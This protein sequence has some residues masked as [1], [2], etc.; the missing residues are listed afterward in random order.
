[1]PAGTV[2]AIV[3]GLSLVL[4]QLEDRLADANSAADQLAALGI[5]FP[6][7]ALALLTSDISQIHGA[8]APLKQARQD[9][10]T[11]IS[12]NVDAIQIVA[13]GATVVTAVG[14]LIGKIE[15]LENT[16]KN[17]S[18][19]GAGVSAT[20]LTAY[21]ESFGRRLV[22]D[23]LISYLSER[24]PTFTGVLSLLGVVDN[25]PAPGDP[26]NPA[27]PAYMVRDLHLDRL[28]QAVQSPKDLLQ[29]LYGWGNPN[30]D[31]QNL[32]T[33]IAAFL[34]NLGMVARVESPSPGTI[35]LK[36]LFLD[37]K[38]DPSVSPEG[39]SG[40]FHS[41][42][43]D[44]AT[45][46]F[47]LAPNWN[48]QIAVHGKFDAE[49]GFKIA[50]PLAINLQPAANF[51]GSITAD[52]TRSGPPLIILGEADGSRLEAASVSAGAKADILVDA[53][54]GTHVV[55]G[56]S[57]G[58]SGGK[59]VIDGSKGDGFL[60][61][62][63]SGVHI[64]SDF[65]VQGTWDSVRGVQISGGGGLD[66]ALPVHADLGPIS[67]PTLHL[68]TTLGNGGITI[69]ISADLNAK[70]GP[71]AASVER[72][73][74]NANVTFPKPHGN[75][76]PLNIEFSFH[77]PTGVGASIDAGIVSGGGFLGFDPQRK[78]YSG[79]L[80]L[81]LADIVSVK[82]IGIIDTELPDGTPGYSFIIVITTDF[83]PI[84]LS[85]GFTL[86][87]VGGV[88]GI[89]RTMS[90]DAL[91]DGL[92][93]HHLDSVLFPPDPVANAP[94]I[95]S[96]LRTFFP[97]AAD[98]Y[99]FGPMFSLGW[100][101]PT[102]VKL[103]VGVV[104]EVPDPVRLAILGQ[105]K[106]AL[107]TEDV[108]LIDI[109]IDV[110]GDVDFGAELLSIDGSMYDSHVLIYSTEGDM[111]FRLGWGDNPNF[112]LSVGGLNPRFQ[113]PPG[114]PQMHRARVSIGDGDNPRLACDSYYAVTSNSVQFGASVDLYAEEAGFSIHGYI[115]FDAL[116]I[117]S[118]FSFIIEFHA[119]FDVEFEGASLMSI[120]V[121][122]V[123]S[124]PHPWHVHGDAHFHILF[125]SVSPS[126]DISWGDPTPVLLPP[127]EVWPVL[128]NAL[129]D[130][131]AWTTQFPADATPSVSLAPRPP[132]DTT[133]IVHPLGTLQV[134]E[135]VVP[136]DLTISKF[137]SG[138]P[139]DGTYFTI[140]GVTI[141][142]QS[143]MKQS[144]TDNFA[145]GQFADLSDDDKLGKPSYQPFDNG[146]AIGSHDVVF[147]R[148]VPRTV[149]YEDGYI[150]EDNQVMRFGR[151]FAL[152]LDLHL[153]YSRLGAS[154]TAGM[155]TSGL[156]KYTKAGTVGAVKSA[157]ISY[158]IAGTDDLVIRNDLSAATSHAAASAA[159]QSYLQANP[160]T[161]G[162]LQVVA[163][164]EAMAA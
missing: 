136:L 63:L 73:G 31:A 113:P 96:D 139:S 86:N 70:L 57:V 14:V 140:A 91:R 132:S 129:E 35:V 16:V 11:L 158:V 50:P 141:D 164:H 68:V 150:D 115:G 106:I 92:R 89:N 23:L 109:N 8:V 46:S 75:L 12:G 119:G 120:G 13:A 111:A 97:P 102:L 21:A 15:Q 124:G 161:A 80:E 105:L 85:F 159:L 155:M 49:L 148:D 163:M 3:R 45:E 87:G 19:A 71:I 98:R 131:R 51:T 4:E 162:T 135:K 110:L 66:L 107:P 157:D 69:E 99:V 114:F 122:A 149:V 59:A 37:L 79:V 151:H 29:S 22:A 146:I 93:A 121:N 152:P 95:I 56:L 100:G 127:V 82:A 153:A 10:E 112:A 28:P 41:A 30:F 118:P 101:T 144:L 123:L 116:F 134:R 84:Q 125:I 128:Q 81:S 126:I 94:Q 7:A 62:I 27:K 108:P 130:P 38:P 145:I 33:Q 64:E 20:E 147:S 2:E 143:E 142:N 47:A 40:A 58:L 55:P 138:K 78:E 34:G 44:G 25:Y 104:L 117:L 43:E 17:L 133:L 72:L 9:L 61:T 77:A 24:A 160:A 60:S 65:E 39:L 48:V 76:G 74:V 42:V 83:P 36:S 1:M 103:N 18:P 26:A 156:S 53:A 67:L 52:L 137:G 54:N 5:R 32:L 6:P 88:C 154:F 90:L